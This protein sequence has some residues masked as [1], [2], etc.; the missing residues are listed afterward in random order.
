MMNINTLKKEGNTFIVDKEFDSY[1]LIEDNVDI[2]VKENINVTFVD[3]TNNK[4]IN[5]SSEENTNISYFS[6]LSLNS[7][8]TFDIKG[9]LDL[10]SISLDNTEESIKINLLSKGAKLNQ[11]TLAISKDE[12]M[13]F[14]QYVSHKAKNTESDISNF[15]ICIRNANIKFD[16]TGKIEKD[17]NK[18]R[19]SQLSKGYLMD[20]KSI[21]S[22]L[23]I[24][25]IDEYDSMANHGAAI[26]KMSDDELFYLMSR[27]LSKEEAFMLIING[28]IRPFVN[29]IIDEKLKE[30]IN[31]KIES[32]IRE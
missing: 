23:P 22:S 18:S 27:G 1:I 12:N 29:N 7:N 10:V 24:L 11:R 2:L 14:N 5:L 30:E 28:I 19:C 9:N 13:I 20:D 26:G 6:L 32:M 17:M 15:G 8:K 4:N 31:N 16:T 21:I 3:K 25:L